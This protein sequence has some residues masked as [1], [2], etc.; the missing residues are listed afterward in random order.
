[1]H[2]HFTLFLPSLII[3]YNLSCQEVIRCL[4]LRNLKGELEESI[5]EHFTCFQIE[6][7]DLAIDEFLK[8]KYFPSSLTNSFLLGS[9]HY[10]QIRYILGHNWKECSMNITL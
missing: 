3:F 9:P 6:C 2:N 1:M 4:S 7:G 5:I 8:I 10:S